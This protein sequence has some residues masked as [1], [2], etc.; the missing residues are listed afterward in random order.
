MVYKFILYNDLNSIV[1][2]S[3]IGGVIL[4]KICLLKLFKKQLPKYSK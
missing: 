3:I 2:L 4:L 1:F